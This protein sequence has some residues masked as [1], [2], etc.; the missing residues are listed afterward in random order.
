VVSAA[1]STSIGTRMPV[2]TSASAT[3]PR[4][5]IHRQRAAERLADG[6]AEPNVGQLEAVVG[7]GRAGR[8]E[9]VVADAGHTEV[10]LRSARPVATVARCTSTSSP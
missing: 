5:R 4:I 9:G 7:I 8:V 1:I 2:A 6:V 10:H 3:I